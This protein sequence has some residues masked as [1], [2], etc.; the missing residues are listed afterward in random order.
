MPD[1]V[2]LEWTYSPT[3]FFEEAITMEHEDYEMKID[4]G[5]VEARMHPDIYDKRP[6]M[7]NDLHEALDYR[8]LSNQLLAHKPYNLSKSSESRLHEDGR[9]DVRVFAES[10]LLTCVGLSVDI[11]VKDKDG[12][13]KTDTRKERLDRNKEMA[14]LVEKHRSKDGLLGSLLK[15]YSHAV[16]NPENELVHLYEIHEALKTRFGKKKAPTELGVGEEWST[17][18]RLADDEPLRQGRHR[19]RNAESLRDATEAEL[20][21]ARGIARGLIEGYLRYLERAGEPKNASAASSHD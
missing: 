2:V 14:S 12:N 9:R 7:R 19:G 10:V 6:T 1:I 15:S 20:K 3:D 5:R 8:F 13:I 21:E 16:T 18:Q 11:Q 4:G 17:L